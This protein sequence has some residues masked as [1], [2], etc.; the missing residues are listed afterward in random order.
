MSYL[1]TRDIDLELNNNY[2]INNNL[3]IKTGKGDI[4]CLQHG[5]TIFRGQ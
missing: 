5:K 3:H 4:P 2:K 1:S